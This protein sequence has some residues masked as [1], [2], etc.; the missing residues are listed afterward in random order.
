MLRDILIPA[1][2]TILVGL[3]LLAVEY[4]TSWFANQFSTRVKQQYLEPISTNLLDLNVKRLKWV[5][6]ALVVAVPITVIITSVATNATIEH[7]RSQIQAYEQAE[8]W[9]LPETL[10]QLGEVSKEL[11]LTFDERKTLNELEDLVVGLDSAKTQAEN[12]AS[13]LS[14]E[15]AVLLKQIRSL[16]EALIEPGVLGLA[17]GDTA[18]L[19][20]NECYLGLMRVYDSSMIRVMLNDQDQFM[21]I[22]EHVTFH[23]P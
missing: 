3:V 23:L 14:D 1:V 18:E 12:R 20:E 17:E 10:I 4:R 22:A 21:Y 16:E 11:K 15:N 9:G 8:E 7:L 2:V 19:I 5:F 6:G 13:E